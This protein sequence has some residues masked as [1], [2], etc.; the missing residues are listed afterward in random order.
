M[1]GANGSL[2]IFTVFIS[3]PFSYILHNVSNVLNNTRKKVQKIVAEEELSLN[4]LDRVRESDLRG[5]VEG[6]QREKTFGF[7][8][9]SE[10]EY[11]PSEQKQDEDKIITMPKKPKTRIRKK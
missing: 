8:K 5:V 4:N 7:E 3:V 11:Y 6:L 9:F 10:E 2:Q 1:P